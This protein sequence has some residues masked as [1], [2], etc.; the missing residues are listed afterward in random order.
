LVQ[1]NDISGGNTPEVSAGIEFG[2]PRGFVWGSGTPPPTTIGEIIGNKIRAGNGR[3]AYGIRSG[4]TVAGTRIF[5]NDISGGTASSGESWAIGAGDVLLIDTNNLNLDASAPTT[6]AS[7]AWCGGIV[8]WRAV[9][10]ITNNVIFGASAPQS[11]AV[12][13]EQVEGAAREVVLSSNYLSGGPPPAANT[14]A[15]VSAC[16]VLTN[17]GCSGCASAKIGRIRN[18]I[19]AGGAGTKRYGVYEET[20]ANTAFTVHPDRLDNNDLFFGQSSDVLYRY[21]IGTAAPSD[22]VN[23]SAVNLLLFSAQ[24]FTGDPLTDTTFHLGSGSPCINAGIASDAP[25]L[26]FDGDQRPLGNLYD[27]GPDEAQ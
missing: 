2:T 16:V 26:D 22:M 18:N 19:L 3:A 7:S 20:N 25:Q 4:L 17:N 21:W 10:D 11:A 23:L 5:G 1:N 12:R 15:P 9:L 27:V 8:S 14:N 6:C 13:L 24:N